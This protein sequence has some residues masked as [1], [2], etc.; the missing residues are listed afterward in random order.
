MKRRR[1]RE[2]KTEEK[3]RE[4]RKKVRTREK[5]EKGRERRRL[6]GGKERLR[7]RGERKGEN[8]TNTERRE[9]TTARE[10]L[11]KSRR[12][13]DRRKY[14][15]PNVTPAETKRQRHDHAEEER[16]DVPGYKHGRLPRLQ[17]NRIRRRGSE[18]PK[19][20]VDF[21]FGNFHIPLAL[22]PGSDLDLDQ[23]PD[24]RWAQGRTKSGLKQDQRR[25]KAGLMG[26]SDVVE[27]VSSEEP[28]HQELWSTVAVGLWLMGPGGL[29]LTSPLLWAL[30]HCSSDDAAFGPSVPSQ[31]TTS[32]DRTARA[33]PCSVPS[34]RHGLGCGPYRPRAAASS[35]RSWAGRGG[36]V[37]EGVKD[38]RRRRTGQARRCSMPRPGR[39]DSQPGLFGE[40]VRA[41]G[42]QPLGPRIDA[43]ALHRDV[44]LG[45]PLDPLLV[46][47]RAQCGG[48]AHVLHAA[49]TQRGRLITLVLVS[50]GFVASLSGAVVTQGAAQSHVDW[51]RAT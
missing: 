29:V 2:R 22:S 41:A 44:V 15:C 51:M 49:E 20:A 3:E 39:H 43:A 17:C 46:S 12:Q 10:E 23:T 7:E 19:R 37:R 32:R 21:T 31:C 48:A 33:V 9:A 13:R 14:K 34:V 16:R 36:S 18:K 4:E 25:A 38:P 47:L 28:L 1:R 11:H 27:R 35:P 26:L 40:P 30:G 42:A 5:G 45:L 6:R 8:G 24:W 50:V